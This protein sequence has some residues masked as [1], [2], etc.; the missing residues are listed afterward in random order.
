MLHFVGKRNF[1]DTHKPHTHVFNSY[2]E[3]FATAYIEVCY[4]TDS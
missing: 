2:V 3:G 4:E 1:H